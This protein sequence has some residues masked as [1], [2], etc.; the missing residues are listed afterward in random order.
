MKCPKC[1]YVSFDFLDACRKCN[2]NLVD[3]KAQVGLAVLKPGDLDLSVVLQDDLRSFAQPPDD[4]TEESS[5]VMVAEKSFEGPPSEG[6]MTVMLDISD[7]EDQSIAGLASPESLQAS[8]NPPADRVEDESAADLPRQEA[9]RSPTA[10]REPRGFMD[11]ES[12]IDLPPAMESSDNSEVP[13]RP[14][15]TIDMLSDAEL[16]ILEEP[17]ESEQPSKASAE[18]WGSAE[19]LEP[20]SDPSAID[21]SGLRAESEKRERPAAKSPET[22]GKSAGEG[23]ATAPRPAAPKGG[24]V[25]IEM[26]VEDIQEADDQQERKA[27]T[28]DS[29]SDRDSRDTSQTTSFD[30]VLDLENDDV[31][32]EESFLIDLDTLDSEDDDGEQTRNSSS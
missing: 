21:L 16:S 25:T 12:G 17:E 8:W 5:D 22:S 18:L 30:A 15:S 26:D 29:H 27:A 6:Y 7:T 1:S 9:D 32:E 4:M 23:D 19:A 3:F 31:D 11:S 28:R 14:D 24:Y 20:P 10:G 2:V 13:A